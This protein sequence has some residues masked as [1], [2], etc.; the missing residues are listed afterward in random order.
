MIF[1]IVP[2]YSSQFYLLTTSIFLETKYSKVIRELNKS[3]IEVSY[4]LKSNMLAEING[5]SF[6]TS[7]T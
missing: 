5:D 3:L 1:Q 6:N 4:W 7:R 2:S